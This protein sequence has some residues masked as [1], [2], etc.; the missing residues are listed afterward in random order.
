[1]TEDWS[2]KSTGSHLLG[3]VSDTHGFVRPEVA[4][5]F[6]DVEMIIHAG[7]IGKPEV[8][9]SLQTIAPV[10]AVRGNM[11]RGEWA[12]SLPEAEVIEVESILLYVR[13]DLGGLDLDPVAAG[14]RAVISGHSHRPAVRKR[15]GVLYVNPGSVGPRRFTYP[16]SLALLHIRGDTLGAQLIKLKTR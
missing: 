13:H 14:F 5:A 11:D 16:V 7:D 1:V 2:P 15:K 8:L 4:K 6:E 10:I 12:R 3:I 9:D